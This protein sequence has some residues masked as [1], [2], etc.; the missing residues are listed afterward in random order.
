MRPL[1]Y[2]FLSTETPIV[3][4]LIGDAEECLMH[5]Q[6][7][8]NEGIHVDSI[9]FP[10]APLGQARLRFMLNAGHTKEQ[11]DHVVHVMSGIAGRFS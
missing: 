8:R 10:A 9:Q 2:H 11:I 5:A 7:L 3:P 1:G 6:A 4:V